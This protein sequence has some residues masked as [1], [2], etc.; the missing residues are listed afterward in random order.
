MYEENYYVMLEQLHQG[1][2]VD[3]NTLLAKDS[4]SEVGSIIT[5]VYLNHER[6]FYYHFDIS[7]KKNRGYH[8]LR[9]TD[10]SLTTGDQL[11]N[12]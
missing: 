10:R 1:A 5:T 12:S 3:L 6:S 9:A 8:D 4:V 7:K 2:S 11:N